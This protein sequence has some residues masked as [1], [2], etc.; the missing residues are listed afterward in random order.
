[1]SNIYA[2]KGE[3]VTCTNGHPVAKIKKEL[4]WGDRPDHDNE[5]EF[6]DG[7]KKPEVGD[8]IEE[9]LCYCGSGYIS[10]HMG[11]VLCFNGKWRE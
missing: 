6:L 3:I 11:S 1:L 4:H 5:L 9:C 7:Q 8:P 2:K 10:G